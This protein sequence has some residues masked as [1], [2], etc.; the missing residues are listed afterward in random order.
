MS[1]DHKVRLGL[2]SEAVG[3][4]AGLG[5]LGGALLLDILD[6]L[7]VAVDLQ[8]SLAA[9]DGVSV[10]HTLLDLLIS[11][12]PVKSLDELLELVVGLGS[13][14]RLTLA[15]GADK[16]GSA[17]AT[18]ITRAVAGEVVTGSSIA[19]LDLEV[20]SGKTSL[21]ITARSRLSATAPLLVNF[22][23]RCEHDQR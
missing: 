20:L 19:A 22:N 12:V 6:S 16:A 14:E 21:L 23:G 1:D 8:E 17:T 2:L 15:L 9:L 3:S 11:G 18:A 5:F 4:L 7:V 13:I 10:A